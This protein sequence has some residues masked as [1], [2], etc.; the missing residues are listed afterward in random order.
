MNT[1]RIGHK[2]SSLLKLS[3]NALKGQGKELRTFLHDEWRELFLHLDF[4]C[5]S[6]ILLNAVSAP[7]AEPAALLRPSGNAAG[8]LTSISIPL[9]SVY[10]FDTS[11]SELSNAAFSVPLA[12]VIISSRNN[13][14]GKRL[15]NAMA[16]GERKFYLS[17][18]S[19][20][21][22]GFV[23]R[24]IFNLRP[25]GPSPTPALCWGGGGGGIAAP[26]LSR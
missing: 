26:V 14:W 21:T 16:Y 11:C 1:E 4:V 18:H 22:Y 23:R 2:I 3:T 15:F 7:T 6:Q 9:Y 20:S 17:C 25:A 10:G 13:H 5:F 8:N 24:A 19:C 12:T